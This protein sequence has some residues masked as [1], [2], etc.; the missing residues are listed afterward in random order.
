MTVLFDLPN[1]IVVS[2]YVLLTLV[3][4]ECFLEARFHTENALYWK[5]RLLIG[6]MIFNTCLYATQLI[7]YACIFFSTAEVV[8]VILYAAITGISFTAVML[9]LVFYVYLNIRFSGFPFR[10][11]EVKAS[12]TRVST[13]MTLY[14]SLL[15]VFIIACVFVGY[16]ITD[17]RDFLHSVSTNYLFISNM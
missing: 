8:R 13:V 16:W 2:T 5:R 6:F 3:W 11:E 15:L 9:V 7:L 10:S 14:V 17:S 4:A 1:C 12:F